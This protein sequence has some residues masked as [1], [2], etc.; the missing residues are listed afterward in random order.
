MTL[1]TQQL[2]YRLGPKKLLEEISLTFAPGKLYGILGPNGSGKSTLLKCLTGIWRPT[3]GK[4]LWQ[5]TL[6]HGL[7][8]L[9][10][11]RTLSLVP[12]SP[13]LPFDFSVLDLV[14]M[15]RYPYRSSTMPK[16]RCPEVVE[17]ALTAVDAW[18]LRKQNVNSLSA[19]EKQRV[20]IARTLSTESP[21]ILLDEPTACLDIRHQLQIWQLLRTLVQQGKVIIV[22]IHDLNA[23]ERFCDHVTILNQGRCI[24]NGTFDEVM[25]PS[26]LKQVF[27]IVSGNPVVQAT[28]F[29]LP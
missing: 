17:W 16:G 22:T 23:T 29:Q 7:D 26:L 5:N 27:G 19:G 11:S 15:G 28:S 18:H 12:Q 14:S 13:S 6:L 3:E 25:Q 8:A 2:G 20:Y 24:A 21:V 1:K 9:E 10:I 4:V